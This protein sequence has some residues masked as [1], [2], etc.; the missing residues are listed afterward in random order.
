M[1]I[2]EAMQGVPHE[3]AERQCGHCDKADPA[4]GAGVRAVLAELAAAAKAAE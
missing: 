1:T 2:G 4:F 3:I